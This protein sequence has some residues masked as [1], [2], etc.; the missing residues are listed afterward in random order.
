MLKTTEKIDLMSA[1][2]I[3]YMP[4]LAHPEDFPE[5]GYTELSLIDLTRLV[6]HFDVFKELQKSNWADPITSE[7]L[8]CVFHSLTSFK[9]LMLVLDA[10]TDVELVAVM[11]PLLLANLKLAEETDGVK[12]HSHLYHFHCI[13]G[14]RVEIHQNPEGKFVKWAICHWW[15][16]GKFWYKY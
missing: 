10:A 6:L 8:K 2:E 16:G 4:L 5:R 15:R 12:R 9:H 7:M 11:Y 14:Q 1:V 3:G 13:G